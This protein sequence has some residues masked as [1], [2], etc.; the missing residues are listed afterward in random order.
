MKVFVFGLRGFPDIQGGVE[1]HCE[2]IYKRI[3][4]NEIEFYVFRRKP[5]ISH[6]DTDYKNIKFIDLISTRIKG[7]EAL[8]HSFIAAI[9][10]IIK[11][12]DL[13][14]IHN[15]G[16]GLVTPLLK[17]FGIKVVLTYHSPNYLHKKWNI[18]GKTMLKIGEY[19]SL[20]LS[21]K[22][23]FVSKYQKEQL[24]QISHKAFHIPNGI[25]N[26]STKADYPSILKEFNLQNNGYILFVGRITPEKGV[27]LLI[28]AYSH[29]NTNKKLVIV[30]DADH[31]SEYYNEIK[32]LTDVN[33]NIIL[34][35]FINNYKLPT[36][37]S[38][39]KLF[40]LSSL[41][42]GFPIVLLEAIKYRCDILVSD[43][44][45]NREIELDKE[46]YF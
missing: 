22:I 26:D 3:S 27:D 32:C 30:G 21:D 17:L 1:I 24:P 18:F 45:A 38:N 37:Y 7:F 16:P 13:V 23:I 33:K 29:L 11:R 20:R 40:V 10:T 9:F 6:K 46:C 34:T 15:I 4:S 14:H 25:D 19:F 41:N 44:P 39:A 31:K 28:K 5:F 42:E 35:G 8:F 2:N 36:L 43:I 12:P